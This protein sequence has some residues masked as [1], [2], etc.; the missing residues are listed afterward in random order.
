MHIAFCTDTNYVMP[1]GV[2]MIS[3]CE[4][5][6]EEE[7]TFNLVITD[8]GSSADEVE[9][10]VQPLLDIASK[11]G[12]HAQTY[13]LK[14]EQLSAFE[15][16]GAGYIS[17][18]AFARIFLPDLL[19]QEIS[20][21]LYLDC[22]I[23]CNGSL[24][25][26]WEPEMPADCPIGA[27]VDLHGNSAMRHYPMHLESQYPYFNSGVLLMN[28]ECWRKNKLIEKVV[29]CA[30]ENST[31]FPM[32]DQDSLNS[33]FRGHIL[34]LSVTYNFQTLFYFEQ[35]LYWMVPFEYVDEI[36]TIKKEENPVLVHY[37][38][39]NKPWKDEWCPL[40]E[41]WIRY[42]NLSIWKDF[43][44]TPLVTRFDRTHVYHEFIDT[45]WM[46]A[47]LFNKGIKPYL[48]FFQ[49]AVKLK[50]KSK[51]ITISSAILNCGANLL[52]KLYSWKTR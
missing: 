32:L 23:A 49:A 47:V 41:I 9:T 37:V 15:C 29:E 3:I 36:R 46:D 50:N 13:S 19:S 30:T 16:H 12:K 8:E 10:K 2:A 35:E 22:D 52:E 39:P 20:K 25:D 44:V 14:K 45:Y 6:Q 5:N 40:A 7:I 18:T 34:P 51:F 43:A 21:V 38:T 33:A 17:T 28:L 24:K 48:R 31:R 4:N 11:Y 27:V 1:T 26:L 42:K